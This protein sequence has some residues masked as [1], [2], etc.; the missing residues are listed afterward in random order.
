ML[1]SSMLFRRVFALVVFG[2]LLLAMGVKV[3]GLRAGQT[4]NG[5]QSV[6]LRVWTDR[7]EYSSGDVLQVNAALQND[8]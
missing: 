3:S 2:V 6:S 1:A 4:S 7:S 5:A 8:R